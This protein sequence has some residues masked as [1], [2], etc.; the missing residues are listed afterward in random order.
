MHVSLV[1]VTPVCFEQGVLATSGLDW[2]RGGHV[3]RAHEL[4]AAQ[5]RSSSNP[6][7]QPQ[8][9]EDVRSSANPHLSGASPT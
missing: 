3:D 4:P 1:R 2:V 8:P 6:A 5:P 9:C 7:V